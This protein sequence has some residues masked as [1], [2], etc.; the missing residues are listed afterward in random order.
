MRFEIQLTECKGTLRTQGGHGSTAHEL[1]CDR[2]EQ[3][4]MKAFEPVI[5]T[6]MSLRVLSHLERQLHSLMYQSAG[7]FVGILSQSHH[8]RS[9]NAFPARRARIQ[10]ASAIRT[11]RNGRAPSLDPNPAHVWRKSPPCETKRN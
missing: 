6:P 8:E 2:G 7:K 10:H 1:A 9:T 3:V 5:K 4:L 11:D